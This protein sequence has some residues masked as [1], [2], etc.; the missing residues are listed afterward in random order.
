MLGPMTICHLKSLLTLTM[1]SAETQELVPIIVT[2]LNNIIDACWP[3]LARYLAILEEIIGKLRI[4]G[5]HCGELEQKI[6]CIKNL[7]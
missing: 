5:A 1:D 6:N 3:R 4:A 2:L 7:H